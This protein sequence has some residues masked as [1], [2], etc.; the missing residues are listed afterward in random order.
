MSMPS[1]QLK[2]SPHAYKGSALTKQEPV[3]QKLSRT[4]LLKEANQQV[5]A[6]LKTMADLMSGD[7]PVP[8]LAGSYF[9]M[10]KEWYPVLKKLEDAAKDA[11]RDAVVAK[12]P[13]G[14]TDA[15][16]DKFEQ[17]MDFGGGKFRVVASQSLPS[18]PDLKLLCHETGLKE[19]QL[20]VQ[21]VSQEFS[22]DKLERL[23]ADGKVTEEQVRAARKP[24]GKPSV[25]VE[26]L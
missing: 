24:K 13:T 9:L 21:V 6:A 26:K 11:L 19:S 5:G 18:E 8:A 20:T 2:P 22:K 14:K 3:E 12:G 16:G 10:H 7:M 17:D 1:K 23:M 25:K 15:G 4:A